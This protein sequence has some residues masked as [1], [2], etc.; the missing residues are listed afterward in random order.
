MP[1]M[2]SSHMYLAPELEWLEQLCLSGYCICHLSFHMGSLNFLMVWQ[3]PIS[4]TSFNSADFLEWV[5]WGSKAQA[6]RFGYTGFIHIHCGR[7]LHKDLNSKRWGLLS[8][9]FWRVTTTYSNAANKITA[10]S[11]E[12]ITL[13]DIMNQMLQ[14]LHLYTLACVCF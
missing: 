10:T 2:D 13:L 4:H 12:V 5:F 8:G 9:L 14:M 7:G 1:R 6:T 3:S 11:G